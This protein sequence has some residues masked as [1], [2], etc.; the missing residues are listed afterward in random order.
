MRA[1][2]LTAA[3]TVMAAAAISASTPA[4]ADGFPYC[5][6]GDP[7]G[8]GSSINSC[9]F[10]TFRQCQG[11]ALNTGVSCV[12][13]PDYAY[14]YTGVDAYAMAPAGPIGDTGYAVVAPAPRVVLEP[15]GY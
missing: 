1:L 9:N 8:S 11:S 2:Y 15:T 5:L 4:R 13:N 10:M 3:A 7:S 14:G 12:R 6:S